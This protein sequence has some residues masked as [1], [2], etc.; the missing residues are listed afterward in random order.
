MC[1]NGGATYIIGK[2]TAKYNLNTST[3]QPTDYIKC[4]FINHK[5]TN[6]ITNSDNNIFNTWM[7]SYHTDEVEVS[8]S[9]TGQIR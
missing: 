7:A 2:I 5:D 3:F 6:E 4:L 1:S 8:E 9:Y